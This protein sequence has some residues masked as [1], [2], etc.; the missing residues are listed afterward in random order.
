LAGAGLKKR[1]FLGRQADAKAPDPPKPR[2]G[3]H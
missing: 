1:T 3:S 2:P